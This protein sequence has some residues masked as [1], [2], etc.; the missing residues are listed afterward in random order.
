METFS[1]DYGR[2][3]GLCTWECEGIE[4]SE[5]RERDKHP[6]KKKKKEKITA[7]L[8]LK[9]HQI[10]SHVLSNFLSNPNKHFLVKGGYLKLHSSVF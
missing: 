8:Q 10:L 9:G 1:R 5:E 2:Q 4:W 3:C 7:K 6:T